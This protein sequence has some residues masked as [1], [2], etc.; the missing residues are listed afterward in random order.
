[1]SFRPP[2]CNCPGEQSDE[3]RPDKERDIRSAGQVQ[4]ASLPTVGGLSGD[5]AAG[6]DSVG[7]DAGYASA[8]RHRHPGLADA[9]PHGARHEGRAGCSAWDWLSRAA[10]DGSRRRNFQG[11]STGAAQNLRGLG[12]APIG[13]GAD[14]ADS[15]VQNLV[16]IGA[17]HRAVE[18]CCSASSPPPSMPIARPAPPPFVEV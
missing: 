8:L 5:C 16:E 1:M 18:S 10:E 13:C 9:G 2:A 3:E 12:T 15:Y 7:A 6:Q 11:H 4:G 17:W 14:S